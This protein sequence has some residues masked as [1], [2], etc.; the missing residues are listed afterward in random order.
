MNKF[1]KTKKCKFCD[2]N[3]IV[4]HDIFNARELTN[5]CESCSDYIRISDNTHPYFF[6]VWKKRDR[7][8]AIHEAKKY[9]DSVQD[10]KKENKQKIIKELESI[11]KGAKH[12]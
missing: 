5:K 7:Y 6:D 8:L 11:V 10:M 4:K 2:E 12:E 9:I 1:M 3:G